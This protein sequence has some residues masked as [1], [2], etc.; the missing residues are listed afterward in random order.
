MADEKKT[1]RRVPKEKKERA[2][3][4]RV[5]SAGRI[6]KRLQQLA[7]LYKR[8]NPDDEVRMV[9]DP[10]HKPDLSNVLGRQVDGYR[11]VKVKELGEE[12]ALPGLSPDEPVR[13]GD[14]VMM[15]IAADEKAERQDQLDRYA[16]EEYTRVEEEFQHSVE[17]I[18]H[19]KGGKTYS[20]RPLGRSV[21]EEVEREV[22]GPET[23][24]ES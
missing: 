8:N 6:N 14:T 13:V 2:P 11:V 24:S 9:Y 5:K 22:E 1:L 20:P 10:Q 21:T 12:N 4:S 19:Q 7:E 17:E 15:A 23:H 16:K 18:V 3:V